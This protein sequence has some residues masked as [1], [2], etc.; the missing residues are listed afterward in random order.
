[1]YRDQLAQ[2]LFTDDRLGWFESND[3]ATAWLEERGY[4]PAERATEEGLISQLP[5][6]AAASSAIRASGR[7]RRAHATA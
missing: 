2:V 6:A 1:M 4:V 3:N 5:S 7:R